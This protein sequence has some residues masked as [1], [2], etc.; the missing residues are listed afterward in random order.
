M[1]EREDWNA[2]YKTGSHGNSEPDPL[3]V[4]AFQEYLEQPARALDLAGGLGRHAI[5]LA[6]REWSVDLVDV[7]EV[8]LEIVRERAAE[9]GVTIHTV[10]HDLTQGI[11]GGEYDLV[12]DFFY[13]ERA[14][15][16]GIPRL[17]KPNGVLVFKTYTE[18]HS[19]LSQGGGPKHP[20]HLLK[21][22]ELLREFSDLEVLYYRETVKEKGVAEMVARKSLRT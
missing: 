1:G 9:R 20:M 16:P 15:L 12:L 17:L 14:L 3:L 7:S 10:Q 13:L 21:S 19:L 8:G 18:R 4:F 5:W 2:R 22:N 11:P 6:E